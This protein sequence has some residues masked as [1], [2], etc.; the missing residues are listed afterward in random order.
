MW[1]FACIAVELVTGR[2]LFRSQ[3]TIEHML[4]VLKLLGTPNQVEMA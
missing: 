2:S 3:S 4:Q 1:G